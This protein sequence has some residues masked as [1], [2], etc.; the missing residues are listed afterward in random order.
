MAQRK[1]K[2]R[3][4]FMTA[5]LKAMENSKAAFYLAFIGIIIQFIHN[6]LAVAGT[7]NLFNSNDPLLLLI[8]EWV[9]AVAIGLFFAGALFY[10]TI[11]AG[12]VKVTR[13]LK[14][15]TKEERRDK[16]QKYDTIVWLFAIFDSLIDAY[17]W[18]YIVFLKSDIA[19]VATLTNE[20]ASKW[21]LLVVIVPIIVMLPQTLR[22]YSGEIEYAK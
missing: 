12:S 20:V 11:K 8:G 21:M 9:L 3:E 22:L 15:E 5:T 19:N 10:F 18:I 6:L 7:F 2:T 16:K 1:K 13:A 14:T 4:S 17:F